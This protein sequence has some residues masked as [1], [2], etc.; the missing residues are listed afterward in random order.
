MTTARKEGYEVKKVRYEKR[1]ISTRDLEQ[2][3]NAM[4]SQALEEEKGIDE[5][6]LVDI[7]DA[8][9]VSK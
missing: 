2:A 1:E 9:E 3:L 8:L 5:M 4:L 6:E 7:V